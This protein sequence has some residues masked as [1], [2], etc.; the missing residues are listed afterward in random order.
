MIA[1]DNKPPEPGVYTDVS[2][3]DY[4]EWDAVNNS[5]LSLMVKSPAHFRARP[6][7]AST[8][9][10]SIG[11]LVHAGRLE[12]LSIH[13][14]Y[15]VL[16]LF[17]LDAENVTANGKPS[18][19]TATTYYRDKLAEFETENAGK[20]IVTADEFDA[21]K[22]MVDALNWHQTAIDCLGPPA[23]YELSIVW[24]DPLTGLRCKARIDA[25]K[26]NRLADLKTTQ[27]ATK[28]SKAIG[29]YGYH[30]QAAFYADG[31]EVLTGER[32]PFWIVAIEKT[33]PYGVRA[34]PMSWDAM[35]AGRTEYKRL[36]ERVAECRAK[37]E[38]PCY[39]DPE[40]WELP[41]YMQQ[42]IE[43]MIDGVSLEV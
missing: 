16:P 5:W 1:K 26:P 7:I 21:M 35:D 41:E 24:D 39:D 15:A 13:Q 42:P 11:R 31:W 33:E 40:S 2:F 30:R 4:C 17:H 29:N 6:P 27:D 3:E 25:K 34:A 37:D 12:P 18:Q 19:S 23:H 14:R 28:F 20:E 38:W 43:L 10:L 8:K 36:L 32:L 22:S 9:A